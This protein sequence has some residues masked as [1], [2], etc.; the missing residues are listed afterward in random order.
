MPGGIH[1]PAAVIMSWPTPNHINPE[2]HGLQ[3]T[4]TTGIL[5]SLAILAVAGR[6]YARLVLLPSFGWDDGL[7]VI[8]L[9]R[10]STSAFMASN[11]TNH[12]PDSFNCTWGHSNSWYA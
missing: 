3:V 8:A 2:T 1:P 6:L 7:I 4:I 12:N 9:V 10:I 5:L 11:W